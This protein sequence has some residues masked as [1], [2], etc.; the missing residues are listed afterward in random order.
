MITLKGKM[1]ILKGEMRIDRYGSRPS[2]QK[3]NA[4]KRALGIP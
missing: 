2:K 1:R 3:K 4:G